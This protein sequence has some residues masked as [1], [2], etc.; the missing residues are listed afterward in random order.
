MFTIHR[1][2]L[3]KI[4]YTKHI[5][6]R[7]I[8]IILQKIKRK[9]I[10]KINNPCSI[11]NDIVQHINHKKKICSV[12][13]YNFIYHKLIEINQDLEKGIYDN[14]KCNCIIVTMTRL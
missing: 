14:K 8:N 13:I 1:T 2:N 9:L 3:Q 11:F 7:N 12:K 5:L 4:N 10:I 6:I